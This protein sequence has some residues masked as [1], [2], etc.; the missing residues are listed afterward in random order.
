MARLCHLRWG[1]PAGVVGGFSAELVFDLRPEAGEEG[2]AGWARGWAR[3]GSEHKTGR[4]R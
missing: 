2:L 1:G 3:D 4:V